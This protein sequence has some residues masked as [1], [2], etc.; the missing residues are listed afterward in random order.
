MVVGSGDRTFV[1][2]SQA[3]PAVNPSLVVC[4]A[5]QSVVSTSGIIFA[6]LN[7]TTVIY[8]NLGAAMSSDGSLAVNGCYEI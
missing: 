1:K 2:Y 8:L 6:Y 5:Y 7:D 3:V 4:P